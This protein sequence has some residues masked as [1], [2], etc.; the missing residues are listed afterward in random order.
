MLRAPWKSPKRRFPTDLVVPHNGHGK[1][2]K[3]LNMHRDGPNSNPEEF[4]A[5]TLPR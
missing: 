5:I 2:V 1:P 4:K 3:F